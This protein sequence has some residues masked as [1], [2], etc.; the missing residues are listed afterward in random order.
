MSSSKCIRKSSN[1]HIISFSSFNERLIAQTGLETDPAKKPKHAHKKRS[2]RT[3]YDMYPWHGD[4]GS[5]VR[6]QYWYHRSYVAALLM[7]LWSEAKAL[8][9]PWDLACFNTVPKPSLYR[10]TYFSSSIIIEPLLITF[11]AYG[12]WSS[13]EA[14]VSSRQQPNQQREVRILRL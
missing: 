7:T 13:K 3:L 1:M 4:P 9:Y 5:N 6:Q 11:I 10:V 14:Q 2:I 12:I 8:E